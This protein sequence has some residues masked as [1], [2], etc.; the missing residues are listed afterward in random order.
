MTELPPEPKGAPVPGLRSEEPATSDEG[1]SR[2]KSAPE[3]SGRTLYAAGLDMLPMG[4]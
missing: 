2:L 4:A 1:S 3:A